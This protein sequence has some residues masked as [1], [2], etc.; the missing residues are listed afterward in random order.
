MNKVK[1]EEKINQLESL[2]EV[3]KVV[4]TKLNLK[5][6]LKTFRKSATTNLNAQFCTIYLIDDEKQMIYSE[7][8][9]D[10]RLEKI[11]MPIGKGISG[12]VAK[13]G[14]RIITNKAYSDKRFASDVDKQI[15]GHT[16]NLCTV[17]MKNYEGKIIGV[18]Q[19]MNKPGGFSTEDAEFLEA[20]SVPA[21]IAVY[22]H[23]LQESMK[24]DEMFKK[25]MKFASKVQQMILPESFPSIEHLDSSV[26]YKPYFQV[27]GDIYNFKKI[28]DH[29]I[30]LVIGDVAGK[31]VSAALVMS[32]VMTFFNTTFTDVK[33][34]KDMC[35]I[36]NNTVYTLTKSKT[37]CSFFYCILDLKENKLY[38][39]NAGHNPPILVSDEG[40]TEFLKGGGPVFGIIK[41]N[42]YEQHE[43]PFHKGDVIFLYTD[44]V[45]E[46]KNNKDEMFGEERLKNTAIICSKTSCDNLS[47]YIENALKDFMNHNTKQADDY[48]IISVKYI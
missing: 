1:L 34:T 20:L 9:D 43:K 14:K 27:S 24:K 47:D 42:V 29:R 26:I 22:K 11:E 12:T 2:L 8:I 25:D 35:G 6:I 40:K 30:G 15:G 39:T 44:G 23:N 16:D 7:D 18:I 46:T 5:D 48:T 41:D 28:N 38:Y 45:T 13:T 33:T 36:L 21:A 4:N 37:F 19:L 10:P 32:T 17:P 31:G 3:S